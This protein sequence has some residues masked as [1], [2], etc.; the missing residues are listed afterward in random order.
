M[1]KQ[2]SQD[3]IYTILHG[4]TEHTVGRVMDKNWKNYQTYDFLSGKNMTKNETL[5]EYMTVLNPESLNVA[6]IDD[7]PQKSKSMLKRASVS[8]KKTSQNEGW[9]G[10]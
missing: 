3:M 5:M 10:C 6:T 9:F 4:I 8:I 1:N 2:L 7:L